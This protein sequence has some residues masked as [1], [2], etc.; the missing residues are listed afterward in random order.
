MASIIIFRF[1]QLV[2]I[3]T[4]GIACSNLTVG[5]RHLA[6]RRPEVAVNCFQ[7]L[8]QSGG[9]CEYESERFLNIMSR[10]DPYVSCKK[11]ILKEKLQSVAIFRKKLIFVMQNE[12]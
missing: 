4:A 10:P 2:Y 12:I 1:L 3:V 5:K 6:Y 7:L 9:M 11:G 8:W